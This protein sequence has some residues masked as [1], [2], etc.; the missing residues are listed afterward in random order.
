MRLQ[1]V[2]V[3]G[4]L[5]ANN[6]V[7]ARSGFQ[8][9]HGGNAVDKAEAIER[10][11]IAQHGVIQRLLDHFPARVMLAAERLPGREVWHQRRIQRVRV[12]IALVVQL[13]GQ[14]HGT[15][16][17]GGGRQHIGR[18][19][20]EVLQRPQDAGHTGQARAIQVVAV[21]GGI[22]GQRHLRP[23]IRFTSLS[24]FMAVM[25]ARA[26]GST[27]RVRAHHSV[28]ACGVLRSSSL[29]RLS[30]VRVAM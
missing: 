26:M 5:R 8:V 20:A 14:M 4:Q 2:L 15:S 1:R 24:P 17:L 11:R 23:I 29:A 10:A 22:E 6:R 7:Q 18:H 19:A 16:E 30:A 9:H 12:Q 27:C 21:G 13:A 3:G 25:T 28:H